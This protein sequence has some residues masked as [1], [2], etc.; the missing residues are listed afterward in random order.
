MVLSVQGEEDLRRLAS[1]YRGGER[2]IRTGIRKGLQKAAKPLAEDV[3]DGAAGD[4]PSR[5]G[6]AAR[7]AGA[8]AAVSFTASARAT[9]VSIRLGTREKY[10]LK[11]MDSGTL[12]HPTYGRPPWVAQAITAGAFTRP[13]EAGA[14]DVRDAV[15]KAVGEALDQIAKEAQ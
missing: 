6:L 8:R 5:G 3:R 13:F 4:L 14:G 15:T 11:A 9:A 12:R 2:H 7:I 10:D 1:A